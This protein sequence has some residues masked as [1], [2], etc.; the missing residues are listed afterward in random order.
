MASGRSTPSSKKPLQLGPAYFSMTIIEVSTIDTNS[1]C[2]EDTEFFP[3]KILNKVE[4][5]MKELSQDSTGR[6]K[7]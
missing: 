1:S 4:E 3:E 5:R 7:R 2:T 6:V